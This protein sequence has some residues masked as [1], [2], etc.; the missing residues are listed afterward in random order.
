[1]RDGVLSSGLRISIPSLGMGYHGGVQPFSGIPWHVLPS[2]STVS[3]DPRLVLK[4]SRHRDP[5]LHGDLLRH[6][7]PKQL[8]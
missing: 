3:C 5:P 2:D 6:L 8:L 4:S 1:M 7:Q